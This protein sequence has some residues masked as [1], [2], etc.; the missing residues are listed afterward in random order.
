MADKTT[1]EMHN[2]FDQAK[3]KIIQLQAVNEHLQQQV[4]RLVSTESNI[5][6]QWTPKYPDPEMFNRDCIKLRPFL[7]RLW[8]KLSSNT[9]WF[10]TEKEKLGYTV[11]RLEGAAANQVLPYIT[12]D[13]V[14]T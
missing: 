12:R 7:T 1:Q 10:S 14:N 9:D 6:V 11:S 13:G 5:K 4:D 8:L 3:T 2:S